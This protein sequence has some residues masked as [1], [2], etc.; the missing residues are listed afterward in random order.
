MR[1]GRILL[2]ALVAWGVAGVA[3]AVTVSFV[4]SINFWESGFDQ[5]NKNAP[6]RSYLEVSNLYTYSHKV[7]FDPA[8]DQV[9]SAQLLLSHK[10]NDH[11]EKDTGQDNG[12][13]PAELW[14]L[15]SQND[16]YIGQLVKSENGWVDQSFVLPADLLAGISGP[17]WT[18][19]LKVGE[20]T[21]GID[22]LWLDKSVLSGTYSYAAQQPP[23][24]DETPILGGETIG[25]PPLL[26][27]AST[28]PEPTTLVLLGSGLL[29]LA[30][31]ARR[32]RG[33]A[34]AS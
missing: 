15:S 28:V 2:A 17:S 21:D 33:A 22:T 14:F 32:K 7:S 10:G 20:T 26:N 3:G 19:A 30:G 4:D 31:V 5:D 25:G 16:I 6:Q 8:A 23:Q 18:L 24:G 12:F 13:K 34:A 11:R 29:G 27:G 1:Y 9:L